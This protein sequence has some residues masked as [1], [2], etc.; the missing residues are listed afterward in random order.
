MLVDVVDARRS[1][2]S[3]VPSLFMAVSSLKRL[4]HVLRNFRMITSIRSRWHN[5]I[6]HWEY[7]IVLIKLWGYFVVFLSNSCLGLSDSHFSYWIAS[8][9]FYRRLSSAHI[10]Y[11]RSRTVWEKTN[12]WE[13]W[14]TQSSARMDEY[15]RVLHQYVPRPF[16]K[17]LANYVRAR[18]CSTAREEIL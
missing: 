13:A 10:L 12:R 11:H 8:L 17:L 3:T 14:K 4:F 16:E 7:Q 9:F 5:H 6:S 15:C 1:V 18:Q 2:V